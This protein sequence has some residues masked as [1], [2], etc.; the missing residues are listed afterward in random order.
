MGLYN[1]NIIGGKSA[2]VSAVE[3]GYTGTESE[4]Y[5]TLGNLGL[6]FSST[7]ATGETTVVFED[8]RLTTESVLDSVYTSIFGVKVKSATFGE[9]TLTLEFPT[10][11]EDMEVKAVVDA[12]VSD[13]LVG[14]SGKDGKDGVDGKDGK[15]GSDGKSA[16]Q[17]ALDGGFEGT[18]E[19]FASLMASGGSGSGGQSGVTGWEL[20]GEYSGNATINLPSQWEEIKLVTMYSTVHAENT[21]SYDEYQK[22]LATANNSYFIARKSLASLNNVSYA[23]WYCY[24]TYITVDE[25]LHTGTSVLSQTKTFVYYKKKVDNVVNLGTES[26]WALWDSLVQVTKDKAIL[27]LPNEF[28]EI[29]IVTISDS[30]LFN[31]VLTYEEV[32]KMTGATTIC[33]YAASSIYMQWKYQPSNNQI[34][35]DSTSSSAANHDF[36]IY[37]KKKADNVLDINDLGEWKLFYENRAV[38]SDKTLPLPED[39]K[40]LYIFIDGMASSSLQNQLATIYVPKSILTTTYKTFYYCRV[41]NTLQSLSVKLTNIYQAST[42]ALYYTIYY[43]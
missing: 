27:S 38:M 26:N 32:S 8:E 19:E 41:N 43:R 39:Y 7:L 37:Y 14:A 1:A 13:N 29:K 5:S 2:Y 6:T 25:F 24:G 35:I 21:I 11:T 30:H 23:Q 12:D 4:F 17:Y 9:G 36:Y 40:E 28:S 3:G 16:Y 34:Y 20:L 10:Q 22:T 31:H 42:S 15:D 33:D 18:E